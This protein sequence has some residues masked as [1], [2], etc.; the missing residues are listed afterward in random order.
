MNTDTLNETL[1]A[2]KLAQD[3]GNAELAQTYVDSWYYNRLSSGDIGIQNKHVN[4]PGVAKLPIPMVPYNPR[5]Y[6]GAMP[7]I[8]ERKPT[9]N[10]QQGDSQESE[11]Q[12]QKEGWLGVRG[13]YRTKMDPN[14]NGSRDSLIAERFDIL[15]IGAFFKKVAIVFKIIVIIIAMVIFYKVLLAFGVRRKPRLI[16]TLIGG[17]VLG[18]MWFGVIDQ[19]TKKKD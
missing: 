2:A 6:P 12:E 15:G 10:V 1:D 4:Q 13:G 5:A 17:A 7:A 3:S 9:F 14:G 19:L 16:A 8:N 18:V 11:Q